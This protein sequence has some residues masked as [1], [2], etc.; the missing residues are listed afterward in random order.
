VV[1]K[2]RDEAAPHPAFHYKEA[3]SFQ[4]SALSK[5]QDFPESLQQAANRQKKPNS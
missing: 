1:S 3:L 4:P 5:D 2:V